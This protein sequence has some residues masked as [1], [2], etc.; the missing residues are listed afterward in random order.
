M[1]ALQLREEGKER[2][3]EE[4]QLVSARVPSALKVEQKKSWEECQEESR[5]QEESSWAEGLKLEEQ[6]EGQKR[7]EMRGVEREVNPGWERE[8]GLLGPEREEGRWEA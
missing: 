3:L 5:D 2:R 7:E 6:R 1:K 4:G 8:A